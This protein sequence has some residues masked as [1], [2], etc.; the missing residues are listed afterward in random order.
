MGIN[1]A[2]AISAMSSMMVLPLENDFLAFLRIC[3]F[4]YDF[5]MDVWEALA[6]MQYMLDLSLQN[7]CGQ[8]PIKK[9]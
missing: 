7:L 1:V 8:Q 9:E 2:Y 6:N 3:T 5:Y 4:C